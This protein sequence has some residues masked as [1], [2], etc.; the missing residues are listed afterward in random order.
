MWYVINKGVGLR[1]CVHDVEKTLNKIQYKFSFWDIDLQI[2]TNI[3]DFNIC[4]NV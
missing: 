3:N 2:S 4:M 1:N